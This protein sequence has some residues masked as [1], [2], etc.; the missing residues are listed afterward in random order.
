MAL[1]VICGPPSWGTPLRNTSY[2]FQSRYRSINAL[3]TADTT[4][5]DT[6]IAGSNAAGVGRWTFQPM[7]DVVRAGYR[8]TLSGKTIVIPGLTMKVLYLGSK[9]F[10]RSLTRGLRGGSTARSDDT[11]PQSLP[12]IPVPDWEVDRDLFNEDV[13]RSDA[14]VEKS[15]GAGFFISSNI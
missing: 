8:R 11:N 9:L 6:A 4:I 10:P 12:W 13:P 2:R 1:R 14:G 5:P 7:D 3:S 15:P